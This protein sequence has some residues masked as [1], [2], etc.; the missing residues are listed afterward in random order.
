MKRLILV[1]A[2]MIASALYIDASAQHIVKK[3]IGTYKENGVVVMSDATTTFMA[4]IVVECEEFKS[5]PY[6]SYANRMLGAQASFVD[7]K[8]YRIV[9]SDIALMEGDDYGFEKNFDKYEGYSASE[10]KVLIS[11]MSASEKS[12]DVAA[13]EAA[14][15]I[16]KLRKAR[17]DMITGE[18]EEG[19]LGAGLEAALREIERLESAYLE[20]FYGRRT[21][22][23]ET[24]TYILQVDGENNTISVARFSEEEGIAPLDDLAK[25]LLFLNITPSQMQYPANDE[26]GSIAI[27]YANNAEVSLCLGN[28]VL[29]SRLMPVYEFGQTVMIAK[30]R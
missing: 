12:T 22:S 18:Q 13:N 14:E 28:D 17:L 3:R 30:P 19:V 11:R 21:V 29:C 24:F 27:R 20:L 26:K 16:F 9:A 5:G 15:T 4:K 1:M 25:S 6:A 2:M 7:R 8:K 10:S 23:Y